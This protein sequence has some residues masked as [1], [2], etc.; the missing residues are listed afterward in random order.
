MRRNF[1][2]AELL[3]ATA[4][5]AI[6]SSILFPTVAG[7]SAKQG[8]AYNLGKIAAA[9]TAYG[10]DYDGYF[11][12]SMSGPYMALQNI[13]NDQSA[14]GWK[15]TD[16]WPL[17]TMPYLKD[18]TLLIDPDR[19]DPANIFSGPPLRSGDPGYLSSANTY[20]NQNRLANF[21]FN[22]TFLS[23]LMIP[24]SKMTDPRPTDYMVSESRSFA[25]AA[26]PAET[27]L[28][29]P[30]A[31]GWSA[32]EVVGKERYE[33][34]GFSFVNAPGMWGVV[35]DASRRIL[36]NTAGPCGGDWCADVAKASIGE[37]TRINFNY[38]NAEKGGNNVA[39]VDGHVSFKTA[40][41]LAAGTNYLTATPHGGDD[42]AGAVI[43]DKSLYMWNLDDEFYG[44]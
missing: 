30:S 1:S 31:R 2:I 21:G 15:R 7:S 32:T 41:Q 24:A 39:F 11:P 12:L 35:G 13:H 37:K 6:L 38:M 43:T 28:L 4:I 18:R 16:M 8:N 9:M 36:F 34:G 27:V 23:P 33:T 25:Q 3:T 40:T 14:F 22:Y 42:L 29:V 44:Q 5:V 10:V 26:K 20:R 19:G 17:L